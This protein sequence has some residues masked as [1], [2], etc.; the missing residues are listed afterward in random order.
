MNAVAIRLRFELRRRWKA[1]L[2]LAVVLA[3]LGGGILA[4]AAGSRRTHTAYPRFLEAQRAFDQFII[5]FSQF[6][7][8]GAAITR[9]QLLSLP[10]VEEVHTVVFFENSEQ[11]VSFVGSNDPAFGVSF[12]IPKV[13]EGRMP[14]PDSTD[15]VAVPIGL[16]E[17]LGLHVGET[18]DVTFSEPSAPPDFEP[19]PKPSIKLRITGS[20]ALPGELPPSGD[21][22]PFMRVSRGFY[23]R[24]AP[25]MFTTTFWYVRLHRA[26]QLASFRAGLDRF[27]GGKPVIGFT[28][29]AVSKNVQR[30][31]ALQA[32]ALS[33]L[34]LLLAVAGAAIFGQ[35]LARQTAL[36]GAE[37][38]VLRSLGMT[39][40][41][42]VVTGIARAAIVG[43]V[44]GIGSML[45]AFLLSPLTPTGLA[46]VAETSPG[47]AFDALVVG[48]GAAAVAGTVFLLG[49]LPAWLAARRAS[50]G[51]DAAREEAPKG[52]TLVRLVSRRFGRSPAAV[53]GVRFALEPGRGRTAVPVR[54]TIL[55]AVLGLAALSMAFTFGGGLNNLLATPRLYGA[56]WDA[57]V[58]AVAEPDPEAMRDAM[59][60]AA[61]DPAARRVTVGV[62]AIPFLIDG[63]P[64]DA[65]SFPP[66]E[67]TFHPP[68]LAGRM[69]R[70]DD[71]LIVGTKTL[72]LTGK[73]VGDTV[74]VSALGTDPVPFKI[75][76]VGVIP[77]TGHTGN[78][79]EGTFT[80]FGAIANLFNALVE[81]LNEFMISFQPSADR[82]A[83]IDRIRE[84]L[85]EAFEVEA[86]RAPADIVNFG[87]NRN[88]PFV[89]AGLL[90]LVAAGTI[91]H[92]LVTGITRRR[93]D[94]AI[95]K[96]VGFVRRQM[97]GAVAWQASV[98]AGLA[99]VVGIPLGVA[100]GRW[101]WTGYAESLGVIPVAVVAWLPVLLAAPIALALANLIAIWPA[102]SAARTPAAE[103][104]RAE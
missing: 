102:R 19:K 30:S 73:R 82:R 89:L 17:E 25:E 42:L 41:Q 16:I 48:G 53:T 78:I 55:G 90:A 66:D 63:V 54:S 26:D 44:G 51:I 91:A 69:P 98:L 76:G 20:F 61:Q 7:P 4:A 9:E 88:L 81:D 22:A 35:T 13:I 65:L 95:L 93:R 33:L 97:R 52:S 2:S 92:V 12:N 103:V 57:H 59:Q 11:L 37:Y 99:V 23:Q 34:A 29:Q 27:S 94:L 18:I 87:R 32:T 56:T 100:A 5:D 46:R 77:A 1:W 64:A 79:G 70:A 6:G 31:F 38:P 96:S 28:Q 14:A 8:G 58:R 104:L 71:E 45:V 49:V 86:A 21:I 80:T 74:G 39:Q 83:A 101:L 75:V 24:Y 47:F 50:V 3:V 60:K 40:T 62:S 36:E 10:E 43:I 85:G 68:L 72:R 67:P 84:T 15:E